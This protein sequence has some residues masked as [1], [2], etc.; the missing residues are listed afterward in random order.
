MRRGSGDGRRVG[1]GIEGEVG[2]RG[3]G[4]EGKWDGGEVEWRG[5]GMEGKWKG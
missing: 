4:M 1:S 5:S 3:S 2:W